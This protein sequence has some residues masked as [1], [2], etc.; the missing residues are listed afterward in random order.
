MA[1]MKFN[2]ELPNLPEIKAVVHKTGQVG[3]RAKR[4]WSDHTKYSDRRG[5]TSRSASSRSLQ[6]GRKQNVERHE[7]IYFDQY[8]GSI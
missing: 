4:Y 2:N 1:G 7:N 3:S 6:T 8:H 5:T